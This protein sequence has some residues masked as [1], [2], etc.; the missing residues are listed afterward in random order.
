MSPIL[1]I[2]LLII[3]GILLLLIEVL[4]IPGTTIAGIIGFGLLIGGIYL[5]FDKYGMNVGIATIAATITISLII[6]IL[7]FRSGTW[8]KLMLN[9]TIDSK[10][11]N[12]EGVKPNIGDEGT[13]L[14][15]LAPIGKVVIKDIEYEALSQNSFIDPKCT[16][17]VTGLES[18][19]IIVKLKS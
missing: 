10:I 17:V 11:D 19:K 9:S 16:I 12:F 2:T 8:N 15:R 3:I 14:T 6:F 1:A 5:A 18:N 7:A 4:V 13:T